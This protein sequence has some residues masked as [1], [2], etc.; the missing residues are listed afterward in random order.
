MLSVYIFACLCATYGLSH[1]SGLSE[2]LFC[3]HPSMFADTVFDYKRIAFGMLSFVFECTVEVIRVAQRS[4][5]FPN[6]QQARANSGEQ[7]SCGFRKDSLV[8]D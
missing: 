8:T 5:L 4:L 6:S 2:A 3:D 7:V 1:I